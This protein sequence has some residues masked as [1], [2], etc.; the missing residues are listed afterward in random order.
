MGRDGIHV[1]DDRRALG[2]EPVLVPLG[3]IA[4]AGHTGA[5]GGNCAAGAVFDDKPA[6]LRLKPSDVN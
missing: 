6:R 4:K 3:H 1:A 5:P 2:A